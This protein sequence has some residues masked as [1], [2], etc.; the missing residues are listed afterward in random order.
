MQQLWL[1][2]I[3][4]DQSFPEEVQEAWKTYYASLSRINELRI[5]RRVVTTNS[6]ENFDIFG[7]GDASEKG[8][9]ACLYALSVDD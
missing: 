2:E 7:F 9:G 3:E 1:C 5:P 8:Y 6:L 4:W